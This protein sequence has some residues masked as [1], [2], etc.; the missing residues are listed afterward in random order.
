LE[1]SIPRKRELQE[2]AKNGKCEAS[3]LPFDLNAEVSRN[4]FFPSLDRIENDKGYLDDN[5]RVVVKAFYDMCRDLDDRT[6]HRIIDAYLNERWRRREAQGKR[7]VW[8]EPAAVDRLTALRGPGESYSDVI[9]RLVEL[10][11]KG[12]T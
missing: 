10:E 1:L 2:Q 6:F 5:V 12:G 8:L 3:D 9:L 11:G 4:P 7:P